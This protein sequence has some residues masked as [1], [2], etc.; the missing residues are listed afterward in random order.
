[1]KVL[2][3]VQVDWRRIEEERNSLQPVS[4]HLTVYIDLVRVHWTVLQRS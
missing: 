2:K 4:V 3:E 1:M